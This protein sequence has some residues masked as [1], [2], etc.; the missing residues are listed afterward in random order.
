MVFIPIGNLRVAV[1]AHALLDLVSLAIHHK[2]RGG[3]MAWIG[4][5]RRASPGV[6]DDQEFFPE[7]SA[8]RRLEARTTTRGLMSSVFGRVCVFLRAIL[9]ARSAAH[10]P[11]LSLA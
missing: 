4:R 11:M 9:R 2:R 6:H 1:A 7:A 10:F 5:W 3:V 8:K